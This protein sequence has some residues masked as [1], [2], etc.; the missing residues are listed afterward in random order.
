[1]IVNTVE[2]RN[3]PLHNCNGQVGLDKIINDK[4]LFAYHI[5]S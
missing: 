3:Q 5:F 4:K 2:D 1:M